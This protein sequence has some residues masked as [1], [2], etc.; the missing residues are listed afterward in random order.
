MLATGSD[1]FK[2]IVVPLLANANDQVR[3]AIYHSGAQVIP[4]DLGP[5]W[6]DLVRG[7]PEEARLNFVADLARNPGSQTTLRKLRSRIQAQ[8]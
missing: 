7:W 8:R 2:D 5:N 1:D 4:A 6:R 3:L